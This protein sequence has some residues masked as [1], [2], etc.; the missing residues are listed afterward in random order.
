[1]KRLGGTKF[2]VCM[3]AMILITAVAIAKGDALA[4]G[5][6]AVVAGAFMGTNGFITGRAIEKGLPDA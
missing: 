2:V 4:F 3:S 6:I 5:S 1:M